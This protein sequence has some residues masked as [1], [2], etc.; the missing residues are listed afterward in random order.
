MSILNMVGGYTVSRPSHLLSFSRI[1]H[2]FSSLHIASLFPPP[3]ANSYGAA[4]ASVSIVIMTMSLFSTQC[5]AHFLLGGTNL[6]IPRQ[7]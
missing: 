5:T 2:L 3:T 1:Q 4:A 7:M 6:S